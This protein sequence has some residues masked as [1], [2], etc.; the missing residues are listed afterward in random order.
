[1][2]AAAVCTQAL[3]RQQQQVQFGVAAVFS[4]P[5]CLLKRFLMWFI[6]VRT[7]QDSLSCF[8]VTSS[9]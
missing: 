2:L 3:D 7:A 8:D 9:A 4:G 1:M 5:C 6:D